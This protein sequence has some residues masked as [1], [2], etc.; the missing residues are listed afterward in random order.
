[1]N[2]GKN[3]SKNNKKVVMYDYYLAI[4]WSQVNCALAIMKNNSLEPKIIE[5]DD[6]QSINLKKLKEKLKEIRGKKI[7]TIEETTSTHWLYVELKEYVNKILVCDPYRNKLLSEGPQNDKTDARKLC[8]LLRNGMLKE[9]FHSLDEDYKIRQLESS[10]E[11][12]VKAG[13]RI[14]NQRSAIYRAIGLRAK[15]DKLP[16]DDIYKAIERNQNKAIELYYEQKEDYDKVFK[17]LKGKNQVVNKLCSIPG[18]AEV[19]AVKIYSRVIEPGRFRNKYKY[20]TYCGLAKQEKESGKKSYGKK[21]P[22]YCRTLKGVYKTAAWAAIG[23]NSDI[24]EYYEYLL[25][26]IHY[27]KEKAINQIARYIAKVSLAIMSNKQSYKPY[28]WRL[29]KDDPQANV[30]LSFSRHN[31]KNKKKTQSG[32]TVSDYSRESAY[33]SAGCSPAEPA[34]VWADNR[35]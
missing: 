16:K 1:M 21:K 10:Y 8:Q 33:P 2:I 28:K 30:P 31:H 18:I 14:L 29:G 27:P 15:K 19:G 13:V 12:I 7:I 24:R 11:D 35:I 23:G 6:E 22:R 4:D 3:K 5:Y 20:W 26:E 25:T 34:Y 9:I 32:I 17:E